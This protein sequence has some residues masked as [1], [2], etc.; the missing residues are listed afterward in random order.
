MCAGHTWNNSAGGYPY[1]QRAHMPVLVLQAA[2]VPLSTQVVVGAGTPRKPAAHVAV[3]EAPTT[4][5]PSGQ[6]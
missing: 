4:V 5:P 1:S 6:L 3:Q 2:V